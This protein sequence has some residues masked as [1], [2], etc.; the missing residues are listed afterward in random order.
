MFKQFVNYCLLALSL[1]LMSSVVVAADKQAVDKQQGDED[2]S[3]AVAAF[4]QEMVNEHG[5]TEQELAVWFD[6][7]EVNQRILKTIKR[8]AESAM[9]WHRYRNI[10][11][12][13]ERIDKGI[14]F[15]KKHE[16]TLTRAEET[17]KVPAEVI[18]GL[19]GVETKYGRIMGKFDIFN[20]LY[21]LGFHFPRRSKFFRKELKEFLIL[22]REQQWP[23]GTI[24]GSYAGAMGYGQ[25]MP[26]SYRMYA[27]DFDNDGKINLLEN[28][29]D[30]IGSVANYIKVHGWKDGGELV[31]K[32][33]IKGDDYRKLLTRSLKPTKPL[34]EFFNAGVTIKHELEPE[35]KAVLIELEQ[36]DHKEY[37]VGLHNFYVISRYNPRVLYTMAVI[38]LTGLIKE[39]YQGQLT[40]EE[41]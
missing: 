15:W 29:V 41:V 11:I 28:P 22:A 9:P 5:F 17:F 39:Q 16:A 21:T 40:G 3:I 23:V 6:T 35:Q 25:F 13:Q 30:A 37:W 31:S 14:E 8:P 33:E 36:E 19:I 24:K 32:A 26:S 2:V 1:S 34:T 7:A 20:S 18:V 38:Q 27:V 4:I 10:F 12:Q